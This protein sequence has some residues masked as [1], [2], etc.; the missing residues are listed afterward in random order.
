MRLISALKVNVIRSIGVIRPYCSK[1]GLK[2]L[3]EQ[4]YDPNHSDELK[5]LSAAIGVFLGILPIWGFQ[6][7]VGISLAVAFKLNKALVLIFSHISLPPLLPL[8][9]FLSYRA[10]G[11]WMGSN[12]SRTGSSLQNFNTH[13]QQ[14]IYGS[15]SLAVSAT[16][17]TGLL[18][19]V[20]LKLIKSVKRYRLEV[21]TKKEL[22]LAYANVGDAAEN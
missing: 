17:T 19:Y 18:T 16:I 13:L 8:V 11:F 22:I 2:L 7:L 4:L 1:K 14:Y 12:L 3:A 9:V 10:G 20:T 15:V 6:T 5:A 21:T